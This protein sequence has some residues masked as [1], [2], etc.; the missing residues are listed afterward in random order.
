[1]IP[2]RMRFQMRVLPSGSWWLVAVT[3]ASLL[4]GVLDESAVL[5]V[6]KPKRLPSR[7]LREVQP[8]LKTFCVGCHGGQKPKANL[9][10][11]KWMN[12]RSV[13][14]DALRLE[15]VL[16]K[17]VDK[18]MPPKESRRNPSGKQREAV[19]QWIREL[20][21]DEAD[22]NSGDPGPVLARRLSNSE[23][24]YTIRDLTGVDIRPTREFPLDPANESGFDN[25]GETLAMTPALLNKYLAAARHVADH[26]VLNHQGI[27][28]APH[29]VVTDT[30]RDKY[31]VQRIVAFYDKQPTDFGD[32][33]K[34]AWEFDSRNVLGRPDV[35]LS[36][37]AKRNGV[38]PSY[39]ERFYKLLAGSEKTDGPENGPLFGLRKRWRAMP[40][41]VSREQTGPTKELQALAGWIRDEREKWE[42]PELTIVAK[43]VQT[44]SQSMVLMKNRTLAS[45][46]TKGKLP[47]NPNKDP[48]IERLR[49]SVAEFCSVIPDAF[50]VSERGRM[51]LKKK[52]RNKGRL[53]SAGF[54]LMTGFFRDDQPLYSLVLDEAGRKELDRLWS[55]L[56][57]VTR[58]PHRQFRDFVFFERAESPRFMKSEEFDFARSEDKDLTSVE[59]VKR[60]AEV[61]VRVAK[62]RNASPLVLTEIQ[63]YFAGMSARIRRVENERQEAES[64][65]LESVL[66][67][68]GRA[69]RRSLESFEREDLLQFYRVQRDKHGLEHEEAIRDLVVAVLMSPQFSY[70]TM[71]ASPGTST[72]ALTGHELASRLSYFLWSSLPDRHL[73]ELASAG[74]LG[75]PGVLRGEIK[76]MLLDQRSDALGIEFLGQ[77]LGVR[78]FEQF[79]AVDR[80]K[81]PGFTPGVRR[82]M[83]QEPSRYFSHMLR[84]NRSILELIEGR[85]TFV[86]KDLARHYGIPWPGKDVRGNA[87]GWVEVK[88]ATS[89]GRGGLLPMGAFLTT[90]SS[91][92]RTSPVRRGYWVVHRLL[93]EHIPPPPPKVPDLPADEADLGELTLREVLAKHRKSEL[94]AKCHSRFDSFGLAFEGYGPVA[95]RRTVD[96][97]GRR[98]D[99]RAEFPGG[100]VGVGLEGLRQELVTQRRKQ[101]VENVVRRLFVYALGRRLMLSD[102]SAIEGAILALERGEFRSQL[103]VEKIVLSR[104]FLQKRDREFKPNR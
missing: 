35:S 56:D 51:H 43:V 9:N 42:I 89:F 5:A 18:T 50:Y 59:K 41:A 69:Y 66:R 78:Q 21:R 83:H 58:V 23:Y 96:G 95:R 27:S 3:W 101:F 77:W 26:L 45:N 28:F 11:Q 104:Q 49:R 88:D 75:R 14:A 80:K 12:A 94:C 8:F 19:V 100:R 91:G 24:D 67:F 30:D 87:D 61:Y 71:E 64:R 52:D 63:R 44:G 47:P 90:N 38:S 97:G 73:L 33:L 16:E 99:V 39:M 84:T 1:M 57:F 46:R 31:C 102:R 7:F 6:E 68:A 54:H 10:L 79:N 25:S 36:G 2:V 17:L 65:Q 20:Q 86:N 60:L 103:L 34:T 37:L 70:Q 4:T 98:V 74:S 53:L 92:L 13:A 15:L 82:A 48:Q 72:T 81:F 22:R 93:G 62:S 40:V 55:E 76:R 32:Y 85:H 29:P